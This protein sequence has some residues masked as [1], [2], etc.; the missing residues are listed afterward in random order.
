M[1]TLPTVVSME[2]AKVRAQKEVDS[3]RAFAGQQYIDGLLPVEANP[4]VWWKKYDV[5]FPNLSQVARRYLAIPATTAPVERL[6]LVAGQ[7]VTAKRNR[8]CPE[9]VT[10]L[11]FL[12][13]D[14][15]L[16]RQIQFKRF[17]E[18]MDMDGDVE[19]VE[20]WRSKSRG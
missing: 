1:P 17:L 11:V 19:V 6:F 3:Y 16:F 13:E 10:L 20:S 9:T 4:L 2:H 15:P 7:V 5:N 18:S 14:L 12:H 8:L